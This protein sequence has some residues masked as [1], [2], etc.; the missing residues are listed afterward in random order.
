MWTYQ[1]SDGELL[2]DG[3]FIGTGYS[4]AGDGRNNPAQEA[5]QNAGPIPRGLYMIAPARFSERLGPIVMNL[6]PL[7]DTDVFGRTVFRIHGDSANHDA[8]HGCVVL[9]P[10]IRRL[11]ADSPDKNLTVIE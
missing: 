4:G 5:V 6:D 2:H 11:I 9:G 7:P 3:E 1:Q 8:S 10:S